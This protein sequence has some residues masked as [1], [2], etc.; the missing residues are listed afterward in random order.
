MD[1]TV[2]EFSDFRLSIV[3]YE[4]RETMFVYY[5]HYS[6]IEEARARL[7]A[8]FLI[9]KLIYSFIFCTLSSLLYML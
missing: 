7:K 1:N 4:A 5:V 2:S 6:S 8:I 3:L 9:R